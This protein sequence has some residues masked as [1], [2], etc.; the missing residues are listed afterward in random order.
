SCGAVVERAVV[1]GYARSAGSVARRETR[2][3]DR[4][5]GFPA[6]AGG[7]RRRG[8]VDSL[9]AT[10][11]STGWKARVTGEPCV[12]PVRGYAFGLPD[13]VQLRLVPHLLPAHDADL[14]RRPLPPAVAA[15]AAGQRPVLHA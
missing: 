2:F 9:Y 13:A 7:I 15:P 4:D 10:A 1:S 3:P 11:V 8:R 12:A 5:T 6:R 14:L